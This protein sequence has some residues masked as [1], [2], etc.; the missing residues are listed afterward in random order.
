MR[1]GFNSPYARSKVKQMQAKISDEY[2]FEYDVDNFKETGNTIVFTMKFADKIEMI[3]HLAMF[4]PWKSF[5]CNG[6]IYKVVDAGSN[7]MLHLT[8]VTAKEKE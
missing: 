4:A 6:K 7:A 1:A 5:I 8:K 2:G 3:D